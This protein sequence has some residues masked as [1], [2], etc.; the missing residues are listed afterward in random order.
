MALVDGPIFMRN[1]I[2]PE[3]MLEL[4]DQV[5]TAPLHAVSAVGEISIAIMDD[6]LGPNGF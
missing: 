5:P 4:I 1:T 2:L 6:A 3:I